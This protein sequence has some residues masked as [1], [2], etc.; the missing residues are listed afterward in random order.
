MS[1]AN[2]TAEERFLPD[3]T[4]QTLNEVFAVDLD[5]R[6]VPALDALEVELASLYPELGLP[7]PPPSSLGVVSYDVLFERTVASLGLTFG[8]TD[9]LAL[10]AMA[11]I[12][13]GRS[14][15][16]TQVDSSSASAGLTS[17][18]FA[19]DAS[20]FFTGLAS[21]IASLE[22]MLAA[23]TFPADL[24]QQAADL[25]AEANRLEAGLGTLS[26]LQYMP[27]DSSS[28]GR[29]LT[30]IYQQVQQGFEEYE[31]PLP[32]LALAPT[33]SAEEGEALT[34]GDA[35]GIETPRSRATGIKFGDIEVGLSVQPI[36]TFRRG[37][38]ESI[39]TFALRARLDAL[40]R[41]GTGD[42]AEP[43]GIT[44]AGTGDGQSD[45]EFRTTLDLAYGRRIWLSV[46]AG[47]NL[48]MEGTQRRL[49]TTPTAPIQVGAYQTAVNWNP[50]DVLTL[51]I[52]PR[53]NFTRHLTL[54]VLYALQRHGRDRYALAGAQPPDDPTFQ[55]AD[56]EEGTDYSASWFGFSLR[57]SASDWAR[58]QSGGMPVEVE[59]SHRKPV[60]ASDGI[61]PKETIWQVSLRLYRSIFR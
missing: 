34:S 61:V 24:Q 9:W 53:L 56:L 6:L 8:V 48:Q 2:V 23:D 25:I 18:A 50:G 41:F 58:D 31:V 38:D 15:T 37:D 20:A 30:A 21:G 44:D 1:G 16:G 7:A 45:L 14:F 54:S 52:V 43:D 32:D 10:S 19:G 27:T 47:Y 39:P 36:N 59:L 51:S 40:W 26:E 60:S 12:V 55:P 22:S 49:I 13:K 42:P 4:R 57:Y 11:P 5:P 17:G 35:F 33:L 29:D 46:V 28:A 3:G